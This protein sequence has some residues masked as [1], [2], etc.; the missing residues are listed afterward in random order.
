MHVRPNEI[1]LLLLLLVE[2]LRHRGRIGKL[3][4]LLLLLLVLV[5]GLHVAR[6]ELIVEMW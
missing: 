3:W 6:R 4:L 1:V 5:L 2:L